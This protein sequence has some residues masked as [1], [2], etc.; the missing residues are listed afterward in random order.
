[1][2]A[3]DEKV[4]FSGYVDHRAIVKYIEAKRAQNG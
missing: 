4:Q 2:V 1:L 3:I